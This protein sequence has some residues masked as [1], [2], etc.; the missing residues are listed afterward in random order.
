MEFL[1]LEASVALYSAAIFSV[2]HGHISGSRAF[3]EVVGTDVSL[4]HRRLALLLTR[5]S[6]GGETL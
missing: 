1:L 5:P 6:L 2:N 3:W 4:L